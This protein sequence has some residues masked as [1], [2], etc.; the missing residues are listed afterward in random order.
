MLKMTEISNIRNLYFEEGK[1]VTEINRITGKDRKMIKNYALQ[2]R[3]IANRAKLSVKQHNEHLAGAKLKI[4]TFKK[5][6]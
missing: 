4:C 3:L 2:Q 1:N 6:F 5:T